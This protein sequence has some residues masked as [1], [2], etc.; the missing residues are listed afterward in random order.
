MIVENGNSRIELTIMQG[1]N[2]T[3]CTR[4]EFCMRY[5]ALDHRRGVPLAA[6]AILAVAS[7]AL[8]KYLAS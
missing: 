6:L 7:T 5:P 3:S 2:F 8:L 1:F 4:V